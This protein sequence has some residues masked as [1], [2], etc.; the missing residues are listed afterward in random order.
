MEP[1]SRM[2]KQF[3]IVALPLLGF[4]IAV[5][6]KASPYGNIIT[7]LFPHSHIFSIINL[8]RKKNPLSIPYSLDWKYVHTLLLSEGFLWQGSELERERKFHMGT[9]L[10]FSVAFPSSPLPFYH[11]PL[12]QKLDHVDF[13][14]DEAGDP[15]AEP[16]VADRRVVTLLA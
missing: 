13:S 6:R 16:Q 8:S 12:K 11:H 9:T 4:L 2:G 10:F 5:V 14:A 1:V 7:G 3:P 15:M